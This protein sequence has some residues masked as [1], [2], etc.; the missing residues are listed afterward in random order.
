MRQ[1]TFEALPDIFHAVG[2]KS[3]EEQIVNTCVHNLEW[4][5]VRRGLSVTFR[6]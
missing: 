4:S 1:I 3:I 6:L 2:G 5:H